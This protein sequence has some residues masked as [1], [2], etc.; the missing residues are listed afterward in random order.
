MTPIVNQELVRNRLV[1]LRSKLALRRVN[2]GQIQESDSQSS[3]ALDAETNLLALRLRKAISN[4][5]SHVLEMSLPQA[6][7]DQS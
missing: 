5:F 4:Q 3:M 7:S 1:R 2:E 6:T